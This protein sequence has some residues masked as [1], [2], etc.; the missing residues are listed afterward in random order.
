M[1][2]TLTD[3][4]RRGDQ[5]DAL[6]A[7]F[8]EVS[9]LVASW[10]A[11]ANAQNPAQLLEVLSSPADD[12]DHLG[13]TVRATL[14]ALD[15][16]GQPVRLM[17]QWVLTRATHLVTT[18]AGLAAGHDPLAG[19]GTHGVLSGGRG[20]TQT[21]VPPSAVL[22]VLAWVASSLEPGQEFFSFCYSLHT[23]TNLQP[24]VLLIAKDVTSGQWHLANTTQGGLVTMAAWNVAA[25]Q[26]SHATE[27]WGDFLSGPP[28]VLRRPAV[29]KLATPG[30]GYV[31]PLPPVT[32]WDPVVLSADCGVYP[33]QAGTG[34]YAKCPDGSEWM[35]FGPC[36]L[37]VR[38]VDP[39]P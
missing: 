8:S 30:I 22:P 18:H 31:L 21:V 34:G 26:V 6:A 1:A 2:A 14:A 12:A 17:S 7:T 28:F 32:R 23:F 33:R 36:R 5:G 37:A 9:T 35:V 38:L 3:L 10:L 16:G 39:P 29:W 24:L 4:C 25:G 20:H 19:L 13:W 15:G 11:A 27:L